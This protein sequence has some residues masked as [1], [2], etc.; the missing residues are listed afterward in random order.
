MQERLFFFFNFLLLFLKTYSQLFKSWAEQAE[1]L[2]Q[3][4][5]SPTDIPSQ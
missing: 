4:A 1:C 3:H 5:I 2:R